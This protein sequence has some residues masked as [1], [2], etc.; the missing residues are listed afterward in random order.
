MSKMTINYLHIQAHYGNV[1]VT[2]SEAL[3]LDLHKLLQRVCLSRLDSNSLVGII[4]AAC[5]SHNYLAASRAELKKNLLLTKLY[6][7]F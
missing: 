6:Y 7:L 3:S 5:G 1:D 4:S 2:W